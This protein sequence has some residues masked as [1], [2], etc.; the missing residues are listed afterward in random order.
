VAHV[1]E[2]VIRE[3]RDR[4]DL[5]G[6]IGG[7]LQLKRS[8]RNFLGLCPFHQEKTPSF[9]VNPERGI[10][11]CFGCGVTGDAISF[12]MEHDH[13]SF[14]EALRQLAVGAGIDLSPY[15]GR[16]G[17]ASEEF[18]LLYKAHALAARLY[19]ETLRG[20]EGAAARKAIA[21][22]GLTKEVVEAY[23][24]GAAP[25]AW[26]RLLGAARRQGISP[27]I[28]EKG[29]LA[30]RREKG[31]GH[32]DRFRSRLM[33]PIET[34]RTKVIGFGGRVLDDSEPKYLNSPESPLFRKRKTLY[35]LPQAARGIRENR[36]A[37]LVEGYMD[38]L[39]LASAGIGNAVASLGTAFTEEHARLLARSV[40]RV[41][42]VFD[43]DSAGRKAAHQSAG[44]LLASGLEVRMVLL[45]EG[46]DPDSYVRRHG[47]E[48]FLG[49]LERG[50]GVM[51]TLL[52]VPQLK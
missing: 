24:V 9:N 52:G 43:G 7:Y 19:L 47:P 48:D 20:R 50:R 30:I 31:S 46:E 6:L 1:P 13:L 49:V 51:D 15:E 38:V 28:L 2:H 22:R 16:G 33:F 34:A 44:P 29:G 32:Y 8:G 18:D 11:H 21:E 40:D 23:H 27:A 26:D 42:V 10:Y 45:P 25:N 36:E 3:I 37:I 14:P 5:V 12:L 35:G 17:G 41:F 4:T 39:A